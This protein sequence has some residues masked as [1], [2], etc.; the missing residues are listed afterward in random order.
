M[1][2]RRWRVRDIWY[3]HLILSWSAPFFNVSAKVRKSVWQPRIPIQDE[4]GYDRARLRITCNKLLLIIYIYIVFHIICLS[5]ESSKW[6]AME[7]LRGEWLRRISIP[8]RLLSQSI[9]IY[10]YSYGVLYYYF[11]LSF[12][13][14]Y[15]CVL[16]VSFFWYASIYGLLLERAT[17]FYC[18]T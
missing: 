4:W 14:I 16:C 3:L 15:I 5:R 9:C 13:T 17:F 8:T 6:E 1:W 11:S 12:C 10:Q 18:S 7:K 2:G